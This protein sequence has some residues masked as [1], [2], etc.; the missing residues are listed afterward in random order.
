MIN[1]NQSHGANKTTQLLL[2]RYYF[3]IAPNIFFLIVTQDFTQNGEHIF[4]IF[5]LIV[6]FGK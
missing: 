5:K 6:A 1:I 2:V 4:D 3:E